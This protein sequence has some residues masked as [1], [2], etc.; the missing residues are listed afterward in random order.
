MR[1]LLH[2]AVHFRARSLI[3]AH[4]LAA[5]DIAHG[6]QHTQRSHRRNLRRVHRL[7]ERYANVTLA[8]EIVNLIRLDDL[9]QFFKAAAVGKIAIVQKETDVCFVNIL[10]DVD[11]AAAVER[12]RTANDAVHLVALLEQEFGKIGAVLAGDAGN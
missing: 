4:G 9:D 5:A 8:A 6:F 3:E 2:L 7:V 1:D 11:D 12:G 10:E